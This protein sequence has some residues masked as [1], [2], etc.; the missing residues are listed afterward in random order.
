[1]I[2]GLVFNA[3][4]YIAGVSIFIWLVYK[5]IHG[6]GS[7]RDVLFM[8][9]IVLIFTYMFVWRMFSIK[10]VSNIGFFLAYQ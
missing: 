2:H 7:K 6:K 4:V 5:Y 8:L 1:M 9:A 3:A 10:D